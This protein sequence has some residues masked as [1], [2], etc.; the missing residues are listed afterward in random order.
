MK[1]L[2]NEN[3]KALWKEMEHIK[4]WEDTPC[5]CTKRKIFLKCSYY[6]KSSMDSTQS[7]KHI[8]FSTELEKK[9]PKIHMESQKKSENEGSHVKEQSER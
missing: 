8:K 3:Y 9:N 2:Y 7:Y 1:D 6:P 4:K 5:I